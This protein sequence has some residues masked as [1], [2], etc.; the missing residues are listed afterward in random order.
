[1]SKKSE[2]ELQQLYEQ[3][4]MIALRRDME[5]LGMVLF[6]YSNEENWALKQG[7][8]GGVWVAEGFGPEIAHDALI[9]MFGK[10]ILPKI[11]AQKKAIADEAEKKRLAEKEEF[12]L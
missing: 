12:S 1:M 7:L 9:K 4:M 8:E 5:Q 6:E 3:Q 11:H 2:R 10:D